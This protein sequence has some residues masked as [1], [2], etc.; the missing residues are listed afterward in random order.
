MMMS[1]Q[2]EN[3]DKQMKGMILDIQIT[4][5]ELTER[6]EELESKKKDAVFS[7]G[8][9]DH[10]ELLKFREQDLHLFMFSKTVELC[11]VP[12]LLCFSVYTDAI[13]I[14]HCDV[15]LIYV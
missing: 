6:L 7:A 9:F 14:V 5:Q 4:V 12:L 8:T 1:V 15:T 10:L 11:C 3:D 13:I 2:C